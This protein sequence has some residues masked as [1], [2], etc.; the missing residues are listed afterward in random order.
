VTATAVPWSWRLLAQPSTY[1]CWPLHVDGSGVNLWNDSGMTANS[2]QRREQPTSHYSG[3]DHALLLGSKTAGSAHKAHLD[4]MA[5]AWVRRSL[6]MA[7]VRPETSSNCPKR[8][9]L[10]A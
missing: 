6:S 7:R 4:D 10:H 1:Q 5:P 2:S 3:G 9:V 8:C